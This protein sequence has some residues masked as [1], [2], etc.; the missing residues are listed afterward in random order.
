MFSFLESFFTIMPNSVLT[1]ICGVFVLYCLCFSS[2]NK[3]NS[4]LRGIIF[5]FL[6]TWKKKELKG[7]RRTELENNRR[8]TLDKEEGSEK[9]HR[10]R[11]I[12]DLSTTKLHCELK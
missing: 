8:Q 1:R 5:E 12:Y 11:Q 4:V 9:N 2:S 7:F 3:V 6:S 10:S